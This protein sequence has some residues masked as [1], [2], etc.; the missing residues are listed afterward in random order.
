[1]KITK[2]FSIKGY[3]WITKYDTV[4]QRGQALDVEVYT[5]KRLFF[6]YSALY[7]LYIIMMEKTKLSS[8]EGYYCINTVLHRGQALDV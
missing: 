6:Y 1:M 8:T 7:F 4:L 5:I 3:Y 2:L